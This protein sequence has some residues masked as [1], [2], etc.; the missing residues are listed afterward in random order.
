M[1][2]TSIG[3]ASSLHWIL[4]FVLFHIPIARSPCWFGRRESCAQPFLSLINTYGRTMTELQPRAI[5]ILSELFAR[6][7]SLRYL[8]R[9]L[10]TLIFGRAGH[11][12]TL[13]RSRSLRTY[14][15]GASSSHPFWTFLESA[16]Q[17]KC[18]VKMDGRLPPLVP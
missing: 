5:S 9:W 4:P 13:M 3:S 6:R 18:V 12:T 17:F 15:C 16:S 8:S 1:T 14:R 11:L 7:D 2:R 10:S